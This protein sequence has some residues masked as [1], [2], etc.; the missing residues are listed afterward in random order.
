MNPAPRISSLACVLFDLDGT[1]VDTAPDL[2][3]ALNR[4]LLAEGF[5]PVAPDA[6]RAYISHGAEAM[7]RGGLGEGRDAA[8]LRRLHERML[9]E[10][11]RHIA[12]ETSL[13]LGMSEVLDELEKRGIKWGVVTNKQARF[14]EP[15]LRALNLRD[16]SVCVISG[17]TTANSKPHPEPMLA[18]CAQAGSRP[19]ECIYIGDSARDI[20]AGKAAGMQTL[21]A[22]YGYLPEGEN[23]ETWGADALLYTPAELLHWLDRHG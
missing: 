12:D 7:V 20:D 5:M 18:A 14:T 2:I 10:Y 21:A 23:P 4:A 11:G 15:L 19:E 8:L 3:A 16:R 13:Y 1:L 22:A 9:D 6:V 17:D